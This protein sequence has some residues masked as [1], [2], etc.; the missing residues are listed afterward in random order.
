M[1][2]QLNKG[3]RQVAVKRA[4]WARIK[5]LARQAYD[6]TA[7]ARAAAHGFREVLNEAHALRHLTRSVSVNGRNFQ[8][9]TSP[10]FPSPAWDLWI[11]NELH[12]IRPIPGHTEG[13]LLAIL[14]MTKKCPLR[15]AHCFEWNA[16]NGKESLTVQDVLSAVRKFQERGVAQIEFSGGEPLNRYNDLLTI[17]GSIDRVKTDLWILTSGHHL[18]AERA[19][20]LRMVG[21]TG[22]SISV[23]HW[24]GAEHDRFRGAKD[25]FENARKAVA[26]ARSAGLVVALSL[27]PLRSFCTMADLLRYASM[28]R[29]WG[30]HF[31]RIVEP[32]AVGHFADKEVE[33]GPHE[34]EV[35]DEFVRLLHRDRD[36]RDFPIVDHYASYQ[37]Q[38]G[39]SG[40]G[41]RFV[42]VD[43]DGQ[44]HACPFC[45]K[46]CGSVLH[47]PLEE[48]YANM[49]QAGGCHMHA[50]V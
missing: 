17:L 7:E 36:Y 38:V 46:P 34:H 37:R 45:Q 20:Q 39:C 43:T 12:R 35:L 47:E 33:L 6:G 25:A 13:L 28:A 26:H 8:L 14:A 48:L 31:I 3:W 30:A 4:A 50:T 24:S 10:G 21:L 27:V 9:V 5:E 16:L 1:E 29:E 40:S 23:D 44:V 41:K 15:C 11:R 22:V 19:Q 42:Y 18:T 32:R 2:T 49:E